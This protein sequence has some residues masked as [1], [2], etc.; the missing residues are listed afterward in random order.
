VVFALELQLYVGSPFGDIWV[1]QCKRHGPVQVEFSPYSAYDFI[2]MERLQ[3]YQVR[4]S[5]CVCKATLGTISSREIQKQLNTTK[6]LILTDS[7]KAQ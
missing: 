1:A 7:R 5:C 2:L 6:N 3:P 4:V